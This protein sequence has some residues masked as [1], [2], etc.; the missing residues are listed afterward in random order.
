MKFQ[1]FWENPQYR[2]RKK[3]SEDISCD[4]LIVGG[5]LTG[6]SLAYFLHRSKKIVLI[7]KDT[8]ASGAT[9]R[10]AGILTLKG[11]LDLQDIIQKFGRKQG[12]IFWKGNHQGLRLVK[13]IITKE[14]ISCDF[15]P[16]S[17]IYACSESH[18]TSPH[19]LDEYITEKDIER[20]TKL[21]VGKELEKE[22]KT[23]VFRYAILSKGHA[24][25]INP[26]KLTQNLSKVV[27]RK[28][29]RIYEH[30]P[31]THLLGHTAVTPRG[32]IHF[33]KI[34]FAM[35]ADTRNK[36]IKRI[37]STIVVTE[38]LTRKEL[39][40]I[41][42]DKKKIIW[43]SKK[44]YNYLKVTPDRRILLG[45]GDHPVGRHHHNKGPHAPHLARIKLFLARLF[46]DLHE[47]IEYAWSGTFG[48]TDNKVPIIE[49]K[50]DRIVVAGPASQVVSV[51][52]AKHVADLLQ[53]KR[54]VLEGFFRR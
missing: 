27:E 20:S 29:V 5:G 49:W 24:A 34:I 53:N 15:E 51:L 18:E 7:E 12:L 44:I 3:L 41:H 52:T 6:V 22:V 37:E 4:Y 50:R 17:T 33:K 14:K 21:V 9:G 26:L 19:V 40:S 39:H 31:F 23:P 1:V 54:S 35:D 46:P 25:S 28:G 38:P 32:K 45:Y 16:Q 13:N 42:L 10:A 8:V 30:T 43:D 36:K 11:E 48:K 47:R 2:P